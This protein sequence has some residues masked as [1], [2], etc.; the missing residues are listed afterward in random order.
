MISCATITGVKEIIYIGN[1]VP[2]EAVADCGVHDVN[3]ADNIAQNTVIRGLH[4]RYG[5]RL[6]VVSVVADE[7]P[8]EFELIEGLSVKAVRSSG[9]NVVA[10]Y[11]SVMVNYTQML[12]TLL[13]ERSGS[14]V[15]VITN[16]PYIYRA[17]SVLLARQKFPNVKWV[18]FLIGAVEVPEAK[19]PFSLVSRLSRWTVKR[20]E[21]AITYVARTVEDYMPGK[22]YVE[23]VYLI[24][25]ALLDIY[26]QD[27]GLRNEKFT[28]AYTGALTSIYNLDLI[29]EV[30]KQTGSQYRWVFAGAGKYASEIES[31]SADKRFDVNYLGTVSNIE[32]IELQKSSHLL[33]CLKG[34]DHSK[35]NR[36]YSKYAA[37][38]K[39]TEYL[40]SGT[41]VL[42]G[43][44]PAFSESIREFAIFENKQ[45]VGQIVKDI[46]EIK[47]DYSANLDRAL[48]GQ[49]HA[50]RFFNA[51]HQNE[52]IHRFLEDL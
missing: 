26:R 17:M 21:G 18:P 14:D 30:I 29:I 34:G 32:A 43:D 50:L 9:R 31:L 40:C 28:I 38:G 16:G 20:A 33:L 39:L 48:R 46:A 41:P 10:Y 7:G 22:P 1:P 3:V 13:E 6:T 24:E 15:I 12:T 37:S 25:N 11:W 45:T 52:R 44:I 4:E 51:H 27:V 2:V 47:A 35:V 5:Q 49:E 8:A 42:A 23:I 19:F 36:Y